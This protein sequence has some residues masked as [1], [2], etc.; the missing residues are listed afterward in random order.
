MPLLTYC[1]HVLCLQFVAFGVGVTGAT[2]LT[3]AITIS[4]LKLNPEQ[5]ILMP[6]CHQSPRAYSTIK[7]TIKTK[8]P[9]KNINSPIF[10]LLS[11]F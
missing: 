11:K 3:N 2:G 9:V 1:R 10:T 6:P 4:P 8:I 5:K 7:Q